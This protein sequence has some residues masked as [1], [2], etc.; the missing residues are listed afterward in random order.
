[1]AA[2]AFLFGVAVQAALSAASRPCSPDSFRDALPPSASVLSAV[3]VANGGQFGEGAANLPYPTSPT[4]LPELC[5]VIVNVSSSAIS[6]YRFGL[7]LPTQWNS[8]FLAVGNGGFA[9]GINW[10]DMGAGVRYGHAVVSTDTGH[11]S[12]SGDL[13]WA[14]NNEE[15]KI[16]FGYRAMHGSVTLGK[17]LV[18]AYYEKKITY[19]YY[20]GASTGGR[21]GLKEAQ[22]S[23]DS[24]DGLVVGAPAWYT[25]HLQT[26]STRVGVRN[27][28]VSDKK[29]V[30]ASLFSVI[31]EEVIRQ[32]DGKDGL[33]D[34]IVSRP[35]KCNFSLKPLLCSSRGANKSA[36]LTKEQAETVQSFYGDYYAEGKFAFPGLELS[37]ESQWAFLLGGS[38]PSS[39]GDGY[40]QYF[41][42]NDPSWHWEQFN[43]SI[44]WQADAADP[45][46]CTADDYDMTAVKESGAKILLYHG[47]ADALIPQRSSDVLY[48]RIA[49]S[50]GGVG[51]LQSWFR[52]FLVPGMQ[53]VTGTAVDAPW[54]FAGPN[55]QARLGTAV[56]STPGFEDARH[57]A[58]LAMMAWVENGTAIDE[59]VATTWKDSSD[60]SSG[61]LR[62]RP[63]C[64]YP[65][66]QT[67]RGRGNPDVPESFFCK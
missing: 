52:Y 31:G 4:N 65:K 22:I 29:H 62:Q 50:M 27:L 21:Q 51:A 67:Y 47:M 39:Y 20:S 46:N 66:R 18:E 53:H 60:P 3:S 34:G 25:S 33:K 2:A 61:V 43:D 49:A 12:T 48:E 23:P 40:I 13:T 55:S 63:I 37:S 54:Y 44:V 6:N 24:F 41:L 5:A 9:G 36:C 30:N 38:A 17:K 19:S 15:R 11:N 16:D 10:L 42:Y 14:L 32:C 1:M 64:P 58:L 7:F 26:W 59:L 56:Y 35:D 8:R 45:G 28:P 57:D